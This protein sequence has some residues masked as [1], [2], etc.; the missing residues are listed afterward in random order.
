VC[1]FSGD[2]DISNRWLQCGDAEPGQEDVFDGV[3]CGRATEHETQL[4]VS[5]AP[6]PPKTKTQ[7]NKQ[8]CDG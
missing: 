4:E 6:V 7:T 8:R 1:A 5:P 2:G 3:G